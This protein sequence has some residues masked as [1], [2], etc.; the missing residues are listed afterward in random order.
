MYDDAEKEFGAGGERKQIRKTLRE[1]RYPIF[2]SLKINCLCTV[3]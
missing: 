3:R 2:T 1:N